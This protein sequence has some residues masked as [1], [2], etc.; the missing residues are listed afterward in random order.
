MWSATSSVRGGCEYRPTTR[1]VLKR[2][3][4]YA[5]ARTIFNK[6][7]VMAKNNSNSGGGIGFAGLLTIAFVVLKLTKVIAW[8]WWW[9]LA[10]IWI[11]ITITI[12]SL[13]FFLIL[14]IV[15]D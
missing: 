2:T 11:S 6:A 14:Y 1:V 5:R 7:E 12:F 3:T 8:S 13:L 4:G 15:L 10:P 9:V